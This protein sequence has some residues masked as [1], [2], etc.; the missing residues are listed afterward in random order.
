MA[1]LLRGKNIAV[2]HAQ[3]SIASQQRNLMLFVLA[4]VLSIAVPTVVMLYF[5]AW[6]YR[7]SNQTST[8]HPEVT[9]GTAFNVFIWAL[10]TIF[11]IIL[12]FVLVPATHKLQ[13][14]RAIAS[15][16]KPITI[17]V[18]ALR[19]KWLFI[20]PDQQIATVNYVQIP[21]DVPVVFDLTADEAPMS[22]FWIPNLGGQLY[23]MTGHV[24]RLNLM[25]TALGEYK[26]RSAE[27][28]GPGFSGMLF[29][30]KVTSRT[31]FDAWVLKT[32]FGNP[33]LNKTAY[34][35]LL[36]PSQDNPAA[37]YA[38]IDATLYGKAVMKY[39]GSHNHQMS[40]DGAMQ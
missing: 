25:A 35:S 1:F 15:D 3:G 31:D 11:I 8:Y 24:N 4:I 33:T 39:M 27:I 37:S 30:T 34:D 17:Q 38:A 6:R 20:Y 13:P 28:N 19:W 21:K 7:E 9:H 26:G 36:R 29:T 12:A 32:R 5:M 2:L 10:P 23:A 40:M 16:V 22:S 14:S 18:M